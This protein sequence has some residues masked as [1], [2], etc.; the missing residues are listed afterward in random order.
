M[1]SKKLSIHFNQPVVRGDIHLDG[2]KS[3]SNR[4]LI[5]KALSHGADIRLDH[6]STSKDTRLMN[7]LLQ[8]NDDVLDAGAAGTTFRFLTA[9]LAI[10]SKEVTLTGSERMKQRPIGEL[11]NTLNEMGAQIEYLEKEGYPP[12]RFHPT[13]L[14]TFKRNISIQSTISSQYIT[15]LL[16]IGPSLPN[17]LELNLVGEVISRPYIEMTLSMMK[18]FGIEH[19]WIN[20]TITIEPQSYQSNH[21][22]VEG[23]WSAASY[24]YSLAAIADEAELRLFGISDQSLQGDAAIAEIGKLFNISTDYYPDHVI[25]K[26]IQKDLPKSIEW[27]FI[28]CPDLAQTVIAMCA[29]TGISG[30]FTGLQTLRIKETDRIASMKT[31]LKKVRVPF[32][33]LPLKMS[34]QSGLEYYMVEGKATY[35]DIPVF[36][37]YEDHRMAMCIAPLALQHTIEIEDPDVVS[38]SYY[39]FW[40]DLESLGMTAIRNSDF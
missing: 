1:S 22:F 27:D 18:H 14:S 16:M 15:A 11:V 34:K 4:A 13:D 9:Y 24:Y 25:I 29:A 17:G 35:H 8:S 32:Y 33:R 30:V 28:K 10:Q 31:E 6:L 12:L 2:S 23:D 37:T 19:T 26:K 38:K 36:S 3:I 40:K 39:D 20:N 21:L 5:M 7:A